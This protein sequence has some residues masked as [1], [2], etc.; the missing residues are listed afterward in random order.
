MA[1]DRFPSTLQGVLSQ[2]KPVQFTSWK[3]RNKSQP[4]D[5]TYQAIDDVINDIADDVITSSEFIYFSADT[6]NKHAIKIGDHW[7]WK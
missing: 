5:E 4:T 3:H 6:N 1:D 7:F 2:K